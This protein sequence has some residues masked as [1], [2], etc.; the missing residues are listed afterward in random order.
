MSS[1]EISCL[2]KTN[3]N[4]AQNIKVSVGRMSLFSFDLNQINCVLF[5]ILVEF[6]CQKN[7]EMRIMTGKYIL[8]SFLFFGKITIFMKKKFSV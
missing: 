3:A 6:F 5:Y 7:C 4:L 8:I 1:P 2:P